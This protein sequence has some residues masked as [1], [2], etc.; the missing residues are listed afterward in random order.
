MS[1]PIW[2]RLHILAALA[3]R[4]LRHA[5]LV[6]VALSIHA[7]GEPDLME[8]LPEQP[9]RPN[10]PV[11]AF[12]SNRTGASYIYVADAD[13]SH[14]A[15]LAPG[16]SPAWSWDGRQIAFVGGDPLNGPW[17][18]C[19]MNSDGSSQRCL[20]EG[21]APSWSP[22]GRITY[23]SRIPWLPEEASSGGIWVMN[24]DGSGKRLL[25]QHAWAKPFNYVPGYGTESV[26]FPVWSPDG[27]TIAFWLY[28][29][30][31]G[32]RG[33]SLMDSDGSSPRYLRNASGPGAA[34][35]GPRTA[36]G[37]APSQRLLSRSPS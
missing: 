36:P 21:F 7:C 25:L 9:A 20:A 30:Y 2:K 13:G 16:H 19:L 32:E 1:H 18:I 29:G 33:I 11:I 17:P 4:L 22:D 12:V 5:A 35:R 3:P 34:S 14:V 15:E 23:H 31:S 10:Q 6:T 27:R 37:S 28:S 26:Q 8:P 24:A